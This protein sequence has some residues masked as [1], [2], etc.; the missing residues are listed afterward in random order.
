[1]NRTATY[2]CMG[3]KQMKTQVH[4]WKEHIH[5]HKWPLICSICGNN[6][7]NYTFV[8][9]DLSP[10]TN[11]NFVTSGDLNISKHLVSW[12]SE[13]YPFEAATM[14]YVD[15]RF[16]PLRSNMLLKNDIDVNEHEKHVSFISWS[17]FLCS[18][19]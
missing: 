7:S 2:K 10:N 11:F 9:Y 3:Q 17:F 6:I 19:S 1:M 14:L 12:C 15:K 8:V 18:M 4:L 13:S 5:G 16:T